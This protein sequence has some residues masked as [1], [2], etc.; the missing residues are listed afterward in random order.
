MTTNKSDW[1]QKE[2]QT[3]EQLWAS[4]LMMRSRMLEE[5]LTKQDRNL[6]PLNKGNVGLLDIH[7]RRLARQKKF[8]R[9]L[10]LDQQ[11]MKQLQGLG[12]T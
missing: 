3:P 2:Q 8:E 1:S 4:C 6:R 11:Q 7:L 5:A 12:R 9:K 10:Q